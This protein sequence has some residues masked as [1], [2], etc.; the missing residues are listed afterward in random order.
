MPLQKFTLTTDEPTFC[1]SCFQEIH[2][3]PFASLAERK[4]ILCPDCLKKLDI[5]LETREHFGI[6][7]LFLSSYDGLMKQWLMNF[8]EYRDIELAPCFLYP[9][10]PILKIHFPRFLYLPLPSKE[11]RV[12]ER[13]FLHLET[14]LEASHL[15]YSTSFGKRGNQEQKD[16]IGPERNRSNQVFLLPESQALEGKEVVLFDDVFT[17]GSTFKNTLL[18][19]EKCH[20]KK[21]KGLILMDNYRADK[22]RIS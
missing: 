10:L 21:I 22:L 3:A 18:C 1:K 13:G 2:L 19:L 14:M 6:K 12:K 9:F 16:K 7:I 11:E 5:R 20:P 17:T 8:K 4:P 15:V